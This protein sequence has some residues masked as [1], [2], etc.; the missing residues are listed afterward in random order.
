MPQQRGLP[1]EIGSKAPPLAR[2]LTPP[3]ADTRLLEA[4][5]EQVDASPLIRGFGINLAP[6]SRPSAAPGAVSGPPCRD[7]MD[8]AAAEIYRRMTGNKSIVT[9]CKKPVDGPHRGLSRGRMVGQ[10]E[11]IGGLLQSLCDLLSFHQTTSSCSRLAAKRSAHSAWMAR[12][13]PRMAPESRG[14]FS[15]Q[16][17]QR[18]SW[19]RR[20]SGRA[21]WGISKNS[22]RH[23]RLSVSPASFRMRTGLACQ[24]HW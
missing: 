11:V 21:R 3:F 5:L 9:M 13:E 19:C 12:V 20:D 7:L 22:W 15:V 8:R 17:R 10:P 6:G 24:F 2:R 14:W 23:W 16:E 4:F 18:S 1:E